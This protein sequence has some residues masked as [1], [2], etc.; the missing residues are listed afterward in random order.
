MADKLIDLDDS[1]LGS[2]MDTIL[3]GSL[4]EDTP[5]A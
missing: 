4:D 1:V 2:I 3:T 5:P